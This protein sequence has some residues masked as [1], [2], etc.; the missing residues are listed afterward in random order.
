MKKQFFIL[1]MA[2]LFSKIS[3]SQHQ[4]ISEKPSIWKNIQTKTKDSSTLLFAIKN[5]K[6]NVH[7]RYFLMATDNQKGLTDYFANALGGGLRYETAPYH[8]F[9]I[10]ASGF[11]VFNIGSSSFTKPDSTT[12]QLNRYEVAL[13]DIEEPSEKKDIGRLEELYL[14]YNIKKSH[15]IFGRQHIN[16]PFINL[17]DGRMSPTSV[18]GLWTEINEL[19]NTKIEAGLLYQISPRASNNWYFPGQTIGIYPTGVTTTGAKSNYINQLNSKVVAMI[20]VQWQPV[21]YIKLHAWEMFTHNIFNSFLL[22]TDLQYPF[23]KGSVLFASGQM[24]RQDA[25]KDGGNADATKTYFEKN[26]KAMTFGARLGWKTKEI[27]ISINYNRITKHGRY[28]MPREWGRDPFFTFLPRERNE[29]FGDVHAVM[30]KINYNLSKINLKLSL[31]AGYYKLPDVKNYR[32]NKYGL[33]SYTQINADIR[34]TF[35][36]KWNGL[37]VQLLIAGKINSG[38][39]YNNAKFVFNKTNMV[40]YNFVL[41]YHF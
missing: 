2:L 10:A 39:T 33:P 41:N 23:K 27:E 20:G 9:Q 3:K 22:Q 8:G 40:Q 5:G 7:L 28:L 31:G 13:F 34:Y 29:G 1:L 35:P 36:K 30:G 32:L 38:E 4:E 14:K 24:T 16:T 37:D 25:I 11:F 21:K 18:E 17:Q 19:K 12:G 26:G 6:V 15:L